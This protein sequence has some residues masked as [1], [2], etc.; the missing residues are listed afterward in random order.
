MKQQ[1]RKCNQFVAVMRFI[2]ITLGAREGQATTF[3]Y[4]LIY[5]FFSKGGLDEAQSRL[6]K[7]TQHLIAVMESLPGFS[8]VLLPR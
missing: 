3:L 4:V 1:G 2:E 8:K 6:V 5:L 7:A